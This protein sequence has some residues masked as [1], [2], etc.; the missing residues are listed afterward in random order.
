MYSI[1]GIEETTQVKKTS[2]ILC[3]I[4]EKQ[5][6]CEN[7]FYCVFIVVRGMTTSLSLITRVYYLACMF[8][9]YSVFGVSPVGRYQQNLTLV[10]VLD[11]TSVFTCKD[12]LIRV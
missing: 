2:T 10:N 8:N 3:G 6:C 7:S 11:I 4:K 1:Y 5:L 12:N 9:L